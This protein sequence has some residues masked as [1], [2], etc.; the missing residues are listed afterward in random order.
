MTKKQFISILQ[1]R[2]RPLPPQERRELVQDVESHFAF[3]LQNGRT[4]Q[5]IAD[6]LGDPF[7]IARE[8]LGDR[9]LA[10]EVPINEPTRLAKA[11]IMIGLI[12]C[13]LVAVPFLFA[14]W[15]GGAG[16]ALGA[17][18]SVLS[19]VLFVIDSVLQD[20]FYPAKMFLSIALVGF[21][22]LLAQVSL[23]IF[24]ALVKITRGYSNWNARMMKGRNYE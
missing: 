6:E 16:I 18:A 13:G 4:E 11:F 3:G 17:V 24:S 7:E 10:P 22:L 14:M 20:S 15:A 9:F 1:S 23:L 21:G 8:A 5:E 19:P 2:L 12:F